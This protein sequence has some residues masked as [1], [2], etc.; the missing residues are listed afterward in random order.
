MAKSLDLYVIC[1]DGSKYA[2]GFAYADEGFILDTYDL[3]GHKKLVADLCVDP[4]YTL[5]GVACCGI[6][7]APTVAMV[8]QTAGLRGIPLAVAQRTH[9][10]GAVRE[11]LS[12]AELDIYQPRYLLVAGDYST[13]LRA[14]A[15]GERGILGGFPII[16]KPLEQ[17]A[18]RGVSIVNNKQ[19]LHEAVDKALDYGEEYLLEEYLTGTEHSIEGIFGED[20]ELMWFNIVDR[21]FTYKH[22][23]AIE[24][25]HVNPTS[26]DIH[27]QPRFHLMFLAAARALDVSWGAFK[28]DAILTEDGPKIL[29]VTSR[30]SGGWDS[31]GTSPLIGRHPMRMLIQLSCGMPIDEQPQMRQANGYAACAAILPQKSGVVP[32]LPMYSDTVDVKFAIKPGDVIAPACHNGARSGFVLAHADTY[33][34]A[35]KKAH[36]V[37]QELATIIET[38]MIGEGEQSG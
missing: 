36:D 19:E 18:S 25:G 21:L 30:L 26:I 14:N 12:N 15:I 22:G 33:D 31:Q 16:V 4:S 11:A 3:Q 28:I 13:D 34:E 24:I 7:V 32:W 35:W 1:T 29:E 9:N 10:K 5:S 27:M 8:A 37:A 20:G 2:R 17:R 38:K 23:L 6:D